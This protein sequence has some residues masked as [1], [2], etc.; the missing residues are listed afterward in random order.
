MIEIEIEKERYTFL[1]KIVIEMGC[2]GSDITAEQR[3]D[4]LLNLE[5]RIVRHLGL[6]KV[7]TRKFITIEMEGKPF[8]VRVFI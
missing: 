8:D 1:N 3:H 5:G 6:A 4:E 2:C 7:M